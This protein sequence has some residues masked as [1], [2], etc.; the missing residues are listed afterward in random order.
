VSHVALAGLVILLIVLITRLFRGFI[1]QIAVLLS[2]AIGTLVAWPMHLLNFSTVSSAGWIGISAPFRFGHPTFEAAAIIT[3]CIVVLVTYTESTADMLAVAEMVDKELSPNDLA[4]GLAVDGLSTLLAGF[5]NSFPDT[6][7]AENV[8]LVG[9][10]KV[11]SRWVVTACGVALIVVG[12][13]PKIGQIVANIP[14]PV[15]GGAANGDVRDGRRGRHP[16]P[17]QG[18]LRG[19]PKSA[20]RGGVAFGRSDSVDR[21]ELLRELPVGLP[22]HLRLVDHRNRDRGVHPEPGVQPLDASP[23]G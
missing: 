12:L 1:G 4:R 21:A 13:I 22:S 11:R 20:D 10:T 5:M 23:A 8:G 16:N 18:V 19:Q 3:M 14:G 7:Y 6:A 2:I 17:A 15:V 9:L